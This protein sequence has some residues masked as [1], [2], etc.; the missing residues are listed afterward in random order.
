[1]SFSSLEGLCKQKRGEEVTREEMEGEGERDKDQPLPEELKRPYRT[2]V[3][4]SAWHQYPLLG[5]SGWI[6]HNLLLDAAGASGTGDAPVSACSLQWCDLLR[7]W[8]ESEA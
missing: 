7:K 3:F 8:G 1:M 2:G 6:Q 4:P 5:S